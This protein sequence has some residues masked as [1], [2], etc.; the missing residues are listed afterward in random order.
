MRGGT[1]GPVRAL[2]L[3]INE[4]LIEGDAPRQ[5][6]MLAENVV[7]LLFPGLSGVGGGVGG[8]AHLAGWLNQ[9]S[10]NVFDRNTAI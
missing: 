4:R 5:E 1:V 6:G 3:E 8:L 9:G 2:A 10:A 7:E